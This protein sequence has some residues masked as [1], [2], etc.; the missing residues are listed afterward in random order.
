MRLLLIAAL[1]AAAAAASL[2][3]LHGEFVRLRVGMPGTDVWFWVRTDVPYV[4]VQ[5]EAEL[6]AYSRTWTADS[7]IV[8]ADGECVRLR[9]AIDAIA[10]PPDPSVR[11]PV[12]AR[13]YAGILG[14]APGSPV[15]EHWPFWRIGE[16]TLTL[17]KRNAPPTP[18]RAQLYPDAQ[19]PVRVDGV[20]HWARIDLTTDYTWVPWS[21]AHGAPR[22]WTLD[23][24]D[25][26][27][28]SRYARVKIAPWL[29]VDSAS[30]GSHAHAI[31]ASRTIDDPADMA[32]LAEARGWAANASVVLGRRMLQAGFEV[33]TNTL[34]G[35]VW[36]VCTWLHVPMISRIDYL[37]FFVLLLP[38]NLLWVYGVCDSVDYATRVD[39]LTIPDPPYA[40]DGMRL[41]VKGWEVPIPPGALYAPPLPPTLSHGERPVS[42][43]SFRH[44]GFST[45][46]I[47]ATQ[48]A[49]VLIVLTIL[50]GFGFRGFFWHE[51]WTPYDAVAVYS[52]IGVVGVWAGALWA[53]FDFPSVIALWG[54]SVPLM[55]LWLLA[56]ARPFVPANGAIMILSGGTVA[57]YGLVNAADIV[58]ARSWPGPMFARRRWLWTP[59]LLFFAA[60]SVWIFCFYTVW[61]LTLSWHSDHPAV[62]TVCGGSLVVVALIALVVID[63]RHLVHMALRT[64]AYERTQHA[65]SLLVAKLA[66]SQ[67]AALNHTPLTAPDG[68]HPG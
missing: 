18:W 11:I 57:V 23:V 17:M 52:T 9:M 60:W 55:L 27:G 20:P 44:A 22:R 32:V 64:A 35:A 4:T 62:W 65:S 16:T 2:P 15:F 66:A 43:L 48:L 19:V 63:R 13:G 26:A 24:L 36:L 40:P 58:L 14:L 51:H 42:A 33:Q 53:L 5:P 39:A 6:H 59:V 25:A 68:A 31:R 28:R 29:F 10:P 61:R 7:D 54:S 46:L 47:V 3:L 56:A 50:L 45:A 49:Y 30:D 37:T 67:T 41:C 8:C 38:L 1:V 34:T 21:L 12:S